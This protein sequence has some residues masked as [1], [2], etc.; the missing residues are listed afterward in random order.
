MLSTQLRTLGQ[1][2]HDGRVTDM[3][4]ADL[5]AGNEVLLALASSRGGVVLGRL[6][7][8][9]APGTQLE[10]VDILHLPTQVGVGCGVLCG[11]VRGGLVGRGGRAVVW[12]CN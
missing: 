5:G 10:E 11:G 8:P 6:L 1:W 2:E 7:L 12:G 9:R 3:Q 4:V